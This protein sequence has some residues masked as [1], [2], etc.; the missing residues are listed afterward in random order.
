MQYTLNYLRTKVL[1]STNN[2]GR[3]FLGL[4]RRLDGGQLCVEFIFLSLSLLPV[5]QA[6]SVRDLTLLVHVLISHLGTQV[7]FVILDDVADLH[8]VVVP[9]ISSLRQSDAR[10]FGGLATL[11]SDQERTVFVNKLRLL[12]LVLLLLC[13][14]SDLHS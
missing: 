4:L 7:L 11:S 6:A 5:E 10:L 1:K 14:N 12:A 8:Q 3:T 2:F 13:L 9:H